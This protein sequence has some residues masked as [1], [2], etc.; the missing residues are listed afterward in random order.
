MD[1]YT[2]IAFL[3]GSD[4]PSTRLCIDTACQTHGV[5]C[6]GVLLDVAHVPLSRG[7]RNLRRHLRREGAVF[8]LYR[9][10]R[11]LRDSLDQIGRRLVPATGVTA[12]LRRAFPNR[13]CT[14]R[15]LADKYTAARC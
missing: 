1:P 9:L 12:W 14:V 10:L 8:G 3:I 2:K 13:S 5:E 4:S 15:D 7:L 11:V 6:V